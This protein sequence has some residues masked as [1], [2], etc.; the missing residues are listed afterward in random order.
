M[1]L[2]KILW[3][4]FTQHTLVK[5]KFLIIIKITKSC[6]EKIPHK[7]LDKVKFNWLFVKQSSYLEVSPR[8]STFTGG[9]PHP[10]LIC[11]SPTG[12]AALLS[13]QVVEVVNGAL[14]A[15]CNATA[16]KVRIVSTLGAGCGLSTSR[17]A[18]V[19]YKCNA[20]VNKLYSFE[21]HPF[22]ISISFNPFLIKS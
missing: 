16:G 21:I 5:W 4:K 17:R 19:T 15:V 13:S 8:P 9:L 10:V 12:E 1:I 22:K 6:N 7:H 20:D 3:I 18:V 2:L 14:R 11:L